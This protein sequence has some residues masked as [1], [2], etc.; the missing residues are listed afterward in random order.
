MSDL[1]R[2][3]DALDAIQKRAD[4]VNS[5]YSA[6]WEGLIIAYSLVQEI[7]SAEPE[8][9]WIPVTE[10]LPKDGRAV[11]CTVKG[12][13][14]GENWT[15]ADCRYKDGVWETCDEAAYDYWTELSDVLAW[16][17]L[18]EPYGGDR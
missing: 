12:Y 7:P 4:I 17:P 9:R 1:I 2:R 16:M 10:A 13:P 6:F 15:I 14:E 8:Q 5:V 18:P 3:E 11:L